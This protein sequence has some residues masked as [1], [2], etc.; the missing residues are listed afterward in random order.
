MRNLG[1]FTD[2]AG[3]IDGDRTPLAA[4]PRE[5]ATKAERGAGSAAAQRRRS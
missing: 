5:P 1:T 2:E 3:L 4:R